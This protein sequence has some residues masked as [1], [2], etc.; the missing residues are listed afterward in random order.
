MLSGR[1]A[2]ILLLALRRRTVRALRR[3][4]V[5]SAVLLLRSAVLLL[6]SAVLLLR[7]ARR[8]PLVTARG[9]G[10]KASRRITIALTATETAG[11]HDYAVSTRA[12]GPRNTLLVAHM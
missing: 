12:P 5:W 6:R 9:A 8:V 10:G 2:R 1:H 4:W 11:L 7:S 3:T